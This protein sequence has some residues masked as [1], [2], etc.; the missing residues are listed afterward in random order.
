MAGKQKKTDKPVTLAFEDA[1]VRLD[2][3]LT[4]LEGETTDLEDS[5]ALFAEGQRLAEY[6]Q[7]QLKVAEERV[8]S[9]IKTSEGLTTKPGLAG[10]DP[11]AD[12]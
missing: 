3:I 4:E 10:E 1:L 7:E 12:A 8:Q 9:L 6:C 2:E 11:E 5:L